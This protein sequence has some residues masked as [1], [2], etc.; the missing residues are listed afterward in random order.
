MGSVN[1]PKDMFLQFVAHPVFVLAGDAAGFVLQGRA[2]IY[3]FMI[4]GGYLLGSIPTGYLVARCKGMDIRKHGSGNIGATNVFRTLGKPFGIF[5]FVCDALK[6]VAAVFLAKAILSS[7]PILWQYEGTLVNH[8]IK[9]MPH[10]VGGIIGGVACILGHNFPVWLKFKGGKGV[11]TSLGVVI[12]LVPLAA[13]VAFA[14]WA[15]FFFLSH[16]VSLASIIG[17][18]A[19][20]ATVACTERGTDR[21]ALLVFTWLAALLIVLRHRENIKR[22]LNGTEHRFGKPKNEPK[23]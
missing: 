20:P 5:V 16:Y 21:E 17:A 12:G 18:L 7:H 3:A 8:T 14:V 23:P 19:V 1:F 10:A 13:A 9:T 15:V 4:L 11:A 2:Q 6:G 22:L